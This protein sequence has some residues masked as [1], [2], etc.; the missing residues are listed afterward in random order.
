MLLSRGPRSGRARRRLCPFLLGCAA[1]FCTPALPADD[2]HPSRYAGQPLVE[3]IEELRGHGLKILY[4]SAVVTSDL[5]VAA[6]PRARSPRAILEEI[7]A[8]HGLAAQEGP[9]GALLIVPAPPPGATETLTG[10][11]LSTSRGTP[12]VGAFVHISGA[13]AGA[14]TRPDGTFS[15]SGL[16]PG[17]YELS[18][19]AAGF[20]PKTIA[21][22]KV[23][24]PRSRL[25]VW[26]DPQPGFAEQVVV[27]PSLHELAGEEPSPRL[28]IDREEARLVPATGSDLG[29]VLEKL[30]GI[31]APDGSAAFYSRGAEARDL[32][33]VLDGLELYAPY[34]MQ[35]FQSP[36]TMVD[37]TIV[38]TLSYL[39]GGY[40]AEFG[41]RH[42]GFVDLST[43]LPRPGQSGL[44]EVGTVNSRAGYGAT[45]SEQ[46]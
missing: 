37:S 36:F 44:V 2:A 16:A 5:L 28:A 10:R 15:L 40:T 35:A 38:D 20:K 6:E 7:L 12:V 23:E 26:L 34:H 43:T 25:T 42:G 41:D 30:P 1:L 33:L 27:T 14:T 22:V 21:A 46:S 45:S 17:T 8:P 13:P 9:A 18:V 31:A 39:G 3:V 11:V 29:Q 24:P 4:S 19:E 32:S